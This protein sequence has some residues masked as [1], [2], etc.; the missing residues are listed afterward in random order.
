MNPFA[1][2]AEP[3]PSNEG[4]EPLDLSAYA[5]P[6]FESG[7]DPQQWRESRAEERGSGG[8]K[9]LGLALSILAIAWLGFSA[10]SAGTYL[11]GQPIGS[12]AFAQWIAI[13]A[14]PLA[15]LAVAR[16]RARRVPRVICAF[17]L[18]DRLVFR[19]G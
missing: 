8:R 15:L 18:D 9:V 17:D 13:T 11:V 12:P 2:R 16:L 5:T 3:V 19:A 7:F 4:A 10:W 14:A 6:S 1:N